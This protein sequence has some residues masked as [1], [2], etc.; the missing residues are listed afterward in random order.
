[1]SESA[2]TG[3]YNAFLE[4]L[5]G[6]KEDQWYLVLFEGS[7]TE[8]SYSW[9]SD[10][11]FSQEDVK[12]FKSSYGGPVKFLQFKVGSREEWTSPDNPFKLRFPCLTDL[13]T[14]VLFR[15]QVDAMRV[16]A[17]RQKD[18]LYLCERSLEYESQIRSGAWS[19]PKIKRVELAKS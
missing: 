8:N 17:V 9:C 6:F 12:K 13:P 4:Q 7:P 5:S 1:M 3:I 16:I 18:L 19:P 10:C 14:A 2:R 11:V 15:G